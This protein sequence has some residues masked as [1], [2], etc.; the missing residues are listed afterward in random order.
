MYL[1]KLVVTTRFTSIMCGNA[2]YGNSGI[3]Q[4]L[5]LLYGNFINA[6]YGK[7]H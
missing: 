7:G 6:S 1:G 4:V 5:N 3:L 2:D